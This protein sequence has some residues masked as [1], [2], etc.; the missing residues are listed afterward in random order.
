[1]RLQITWN[2]SKGLCYWVWKE[3]SKQSTKDKHCN[4]GLKPLGLGSEQINP[5]TKPFLLAMQ[6]QQS[7]SGFFLK[8]KWLNSYWIS[9][10][11]QMQDIQA[12]M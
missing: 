9:E 2:D 11:V 7:L 4:T 6:T 12:Q 10:D 3:E 5:S 8:E 1:M